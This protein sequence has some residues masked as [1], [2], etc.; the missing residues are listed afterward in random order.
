MPQVVVEYSAELAEAFDREGF[1]FAL[2]T[3]GAPIIG[4]EPAK[5]KTRFYAMDDVVIGDGAPGVAMV[6]VNLAILSGRDETAKQ[7]LGE[8]TIELLGQH[9]KPVT[10]VTVQLTVEVTDLDTPNYHKRFIG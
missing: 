2:H 4:G 9:L 1:A 8:F 5:F 3:G 6:H 7:Q 10:G